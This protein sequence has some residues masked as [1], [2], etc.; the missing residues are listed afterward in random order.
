MIAL[1]TESLTVPPRRTLLPQSQRLI[2]FAAL[3]LGLAGCADMSPTQQRM[4][5]GTLIG[6]GGGALIGAM[7]GNAA[8]GAGIGAAA[9]LAGGY[10]Y[11][12]YKE[13][14]QKAYAEGYQQG[15][16]AERSKQ[17]KKD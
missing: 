9:G 1:H 13:S 5:S 7:A 16:S 17:K 6:A 14:Q 10:L 15:R 4:A 12:K 11:E 3:V 8:L 2:L